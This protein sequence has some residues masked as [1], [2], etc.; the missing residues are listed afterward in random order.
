MRKLLPI[1]EKY[2]LPIVEDACQSIL[3][4]IEGKNA[5]TWGNTGAF[6]LH[7][8]KNLNVWSDGGVIVTDDQELAEK[9]QLL[10]NHGLVD[11]ET[12]GLM[13]YN[14]RLDTIQAIV[15]NWLLLKRRK[16]LANELKTLPTMTSTSDNSKKSRF[17]LVHKISNCLSSLH[18]LCRGTRRITETL[19]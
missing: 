12:V 8:L 3:G 17:H 15:G 18:C 13:G 7:P 9:L 19:P 1:A 5:G 4:A 11:R 2:Q 10:R 14:S 16:L 6:S